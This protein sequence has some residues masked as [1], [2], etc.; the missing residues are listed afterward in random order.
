MALYE[1]GFTGLR[2]FGFGQE[3]VCL[4]ACLFA[5]ALACQLTV[6]LLP[7]RSAIP[8]A[9]SHGGRE[10]KGMFVLF[11]LLLFCQNVLDFTPQLHNHSRLF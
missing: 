4:A 5:S 7:P 1:R 2:R 11:I 10:G 8:F 9:P 6:G 3:W